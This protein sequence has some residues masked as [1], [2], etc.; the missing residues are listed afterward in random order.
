VANTPSGHERR[1]L[2]HLT[3]YFEDYGKTQQLVRVLLRLVAQRRGAHCVRLGFA[4]FLPSL[5]VR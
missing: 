3:L 1:A 2:A 5:S 4:T